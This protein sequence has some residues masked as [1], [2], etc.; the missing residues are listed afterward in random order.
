MFKSL[1]GKRAG[2]AREDAALDV[3]LAALLVEAARSDERYEDKEKA[4]IDCILQERFALAPCC[5]KDLRA[6]GEEAQAQANDLHQF[7]KIAKDMPA[8]EK[9]ALVE[10]LW[11]IV[12]SDA[13]RDPH[14]DALI[15]RICGLIYLPDPES[16][17]ARR[18]AEQSL[19]AG[20]ACATPPNG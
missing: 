12:L 17:A 13:E 14:E 8:P 7:T 11:R 18:R 4:L 9:A 16:A 3:A 6:K 1:F 2:E 20:T 19:A 5:A 10:G 15:R